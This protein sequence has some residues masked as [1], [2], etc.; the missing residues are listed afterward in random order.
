MANRSTDLYA[1]AGT[2]GL[3]AAV[4]HGLISLINAAIMTVAAAY[5]A[6]R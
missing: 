4:S 6:T 2:R 1:P 5:L 3:I